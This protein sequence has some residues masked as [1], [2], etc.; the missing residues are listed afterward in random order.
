[1][2]LF[3]KRPATPTL[4]QSLDGLR[5]SV[6]CHA[7]DTAWKIHAALA[8][9]TGKVDAKASFAFALESAALATLV[10]LSAPGRIL[11]E[12]DG[13]AAVANW[14]GVLLLLAG[15]ALSLLAVIPR[16][17]SGSARKEAASN[18]VYF[19]H[20]RHW[21][22]NDLVI[23]MQQGDTLRVLAR[24]I[25]NMSVIAWRK[26]RL[27]QLSMLSGAVGVATLVIA[28]LLTPR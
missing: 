13:L 20:L 21:Q 14:G 4:E 24:Q 1:M 19:G 15:A 6:D 12:L 23:S 3:R 18:Y 25:V 28:A 2:R 9:W 26:H 16:L 27:V 22:P 8:D 10:A 11:S 7:L 5:G 17:R